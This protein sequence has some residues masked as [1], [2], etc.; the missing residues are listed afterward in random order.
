MGDVLHAM[1]AVAALRRAMPDAHLAWAVER[2][3]TELLMSF[4]GERATSSGRDLVD[5]IH[6]VDTRYWRKHPFRPSTI[7][8]IRSVFGLLRAQQYGIAI[9]VQGAAKS[10]FIAKFSHAGSTYGF[11]HP[12]EH[13]ATMFYSAKVNT[14]AAHVIDQNLELCSAAVHQTLTAGEFDLPRSAQAE[15]WCENTLKQLSISK[16]AI[17]NPGSGWGAKCWPTERFA[18]VARSLQRIGM[19]SIVNYGPGEEDLANTVARLSGGTAR[20]FFATI[21]QLIALT[22][23]AS[24][25]IGGDTGPLHLAAAFKIPIVA[26]FGPTDPARNGPYG[27]RSVILRSERSVTSYSHVAVPDPGLQS[28]TVDEVVRAS[29]QLLGVTIG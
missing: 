1:P 20:P 24:L 19:A 16:F 4:E 23:R 29:G 28:I 26:L 11:A 14:R 27:T 9:D 12:R 2:R 22:R 25:F 15:Q 21:P 13:L 7:N 10:A 3:W 18:E 17:L 8:E 6:I 5:S